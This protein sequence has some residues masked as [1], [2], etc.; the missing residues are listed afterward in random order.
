[1]KTIL[2]LTLAIL[3]S[4]TTEKPCIQDCGKLI[5]KFHKRDLKLIEITF[6][7]QCND[8]LV[9]VINLNE[10]QLSNDNGIAY[11]ENEFEILEWYCDEK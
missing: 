11:F 4:C 1:M 3:T 2:L 5:T 6:V 8:T 9:D 10:E 7:N